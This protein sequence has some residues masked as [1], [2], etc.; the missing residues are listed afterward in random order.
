MDVL[1]DLDTIFAFQN[2]KCRIFGGFSNCSLI[3]LFV[4]VAEAKL[5][6]LTVETPEGESI[7]LANISSTDP[8]LSLRQTFKENFSTAHLTQYHLEL[9]DTTEE[10]KDAAGSAGK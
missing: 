10:L 3:F 1:F 5:F 8:V 9:V 4:I 7:L 2:R 6:H